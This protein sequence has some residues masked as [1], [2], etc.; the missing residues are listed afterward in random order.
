MEDLVK[1]INYI[2]YKYE[3]LSNNWAA[4][5]FYIKMNMRMLVK[6]LF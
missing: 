1:L 4:S 6:D 5:E 3:E 2:D